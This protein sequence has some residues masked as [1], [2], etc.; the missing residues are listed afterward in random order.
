ML[1]FN[2][3]RCQVIRTG[4]ARFLALV[5]I[6]CFAAFAQAQ[7]TGKV[8]LNVA[9]FGY[10]PDG[11]SVLDNLK[12]KFEAL[13]TDCTVT[14]TLLDPYHD[15]DQGMASFQH[16]KEFDIV[17]TD[18]C[19]FDDL[20]NGFGGLDALPT[21]WSWYPTADALVGG[22]K[23]FVSSTGRLYALPHWIC[24]N[25]LVNWVSDE[26]AT[27]GQS[28]GEKTGKPVLGDLWGT[29]GLGEF[30]ANALVDLYGVETAQKQ[31]RELAD[32]AEKQRK[33]ESKADSAVK[34]L[35][36]RLPR[37]F[38]EHLAYYH[39]NG[40]LYPY[41]FAV[42]RDASYIGYSETLFYTELGRD[43]SSGSA[44]IAHLTPTEVTISP[45]VMG[46]GHGT[47]SWVDGFVIPKGKLAPK[48]AAIEAFLRFAITSE[49]YACYGQPETHFAIANLLPA[50]AI[51][52]QN[53]GKDEP[54]LGTFLQNFDATFPV[55]ESKLWTGM[56]AAGK[57]LE[58]E[59]QS[60]N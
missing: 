38:R 41:A 3:G 44:V 51:I 59:L 23:A 40:E 34:A 31:L 30:Y 9:V 11:D 1:M 8:S 43:S 2:P 35:V 33:L 21:T 6:F 53:L 50:Y 60:Q 37:D 10:V 19:R 54:L 46:S 27:G 57:I 26:T 12:K 17:E 24:E 14:L 4:F 45:L 25:F 20:V 29:S 22:A 28:G 15:T 49:A 7:T 56:K 39:N 18:L 47:P 48:Q 52:Y 58:S 13:N 42:N 16:F 32:T 55:F 36:Q 5:Q